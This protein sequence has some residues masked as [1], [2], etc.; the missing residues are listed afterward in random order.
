MSLIRPYNQHFLLNQI[1]NQTVT[2]LDKATDDV[3]NL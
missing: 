2:D 3:R 1:Y